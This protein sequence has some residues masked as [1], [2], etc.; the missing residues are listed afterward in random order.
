[1]LAMMQMKLKSKADYSQ[2]LR[3]A[4]GTAASKNL[5]KGIFKPLVLVVK[6]GVWSIIC[7]LAKLGDR[8]IARLI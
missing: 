4:I 5:L 1:M 8:P 6:V 2:C 3:V 7:Y